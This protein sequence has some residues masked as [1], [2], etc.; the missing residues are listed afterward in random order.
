MGNKFQGYSK[1]DHE[2]EKQFKNSNM[3]AF[4]DT[5]N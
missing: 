1:Q 2:E 3:K 4:D 5:T